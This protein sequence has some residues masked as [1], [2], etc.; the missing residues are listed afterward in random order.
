MVGDFFRQA[1]NG[2]LVDVTA[3]FGGG[4]LVSPM[5]ERMDGWLGRERHPLAVSP[6]PDPEQAAPPEPQQDELEWIIE[7]A[8][9]VE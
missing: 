4:S 1:Q 6:D 3:R 9:E 2:R 5:L 8:R 7:Q